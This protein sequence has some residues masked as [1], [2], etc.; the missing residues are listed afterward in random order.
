MSKAIWDTFG[1]TRIT[2]FSLCLYVCVQV[3]AVVVVALHTWFYIYTQGI[4][5]MKVSK[6]HS[7][8]INKF[9]GPEHQ[10]IDDLQTENFRR[11]NIFSEIW[12]SIAL[13]MSSESAQKEAK[14]QGINS[15]AN[16]NYITC[17]LCLH[18]LRK[19]FKTA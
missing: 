12:Y 2:I 3:F 19:M 14:I 5:N 10:V 9:Q 7:V 15:G 8:D 13:S 6:I 11:S 4:E 1:R 16:M 18:L 17:I